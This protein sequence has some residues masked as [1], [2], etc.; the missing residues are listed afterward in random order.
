MIPSSVQQR[1]EFDRIAVAEIPVLMRI[2]IGLC[3]DPDHARD[4][5]Q[6][7]LERAITNY[8]R[9]TPESHLRRWLGT[10]MRNIFRDNWR[11]ANVR[12]EAQVTWLPELTVALPEED[13]PPWKAVSDAELRAALTHVPEPLR[14]TFEIYATERLSYAALAARLNVPLRTVGTRLLRARRRLRELIAAGDGR[15]DN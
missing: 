12:P 5:V 8:N 3:K 2:A 11:K 4:L 14:T 10:I 15:L 9:F 13:A 7:T 1:E 6:D